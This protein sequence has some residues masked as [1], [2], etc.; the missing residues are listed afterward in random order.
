MQIAGWILLGFV[1]GG[2]ATSELMWW[3]YWRR[4]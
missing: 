4:K 3:L 1:V 2:V